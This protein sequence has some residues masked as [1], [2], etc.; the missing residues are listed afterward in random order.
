MRTL[1]I[2][3][4]FLGLTLVAW[5]VVGLAANRASVSG[6]VYVDGNGNGQRDEGEPGLVDVAVSNGSDVVLSDARGRY[7]LDATGTDFVFVIKPAGF[8]LPQDALA[9]PQFFHR[10]ASSPAASHDFALIEAPEAGEDFSV[11]VLAD[12]QP[13]NDKQLDYFRRSIVADVNHPES[14]RF[15]LTLGDIV[16]DVPDLLQPMTEAISALVA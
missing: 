15:G 5:W 9:R 13:Y 14:F 6:V 4:G 1:L 12:P 3:G 11:L 16:G 2:I 7:R 8:K 10:L